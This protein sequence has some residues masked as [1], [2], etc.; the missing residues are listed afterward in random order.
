MTLPRAHPLM[1]VPI[2][3]FNSIPS[4]VYWANADDCKNMRIMTHVVYLVCVFRYIIL[5]R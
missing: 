2:P 4:S 1:C 5:V 3:R